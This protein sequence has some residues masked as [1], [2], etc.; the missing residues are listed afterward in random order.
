MK[1]DTKTIGSALAV[2]AALCLSLLLAAPRAHAQENAS[3]TRP[4]V[5]PLLE[6]RREKMQEHQNELE[7]K[8]E[9]RMQEIASTTAARRAELSHRLEEK[10][11]EIASST[12]ARLEKFRAKFEENKLRILNEHV[13]NI[14]KRLNT[15]VGRYT[16][17]ATRMQ[18]RIDRLNAGNVNTTN[19]AALLATA[20]T[21]LSAA[22]VK[23]DA[24]NPIVDTALASSSPRAAFEELVKP[25]VAAA[26]AALRDAHKALIDV[27]RALKAADPEAEASTSPSSNSSTG[28]DN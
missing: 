20:N 5:R 4:G 1:T 24:I 8:R 23:V 28:G 11:M 2:L 17:I 3:S 21:K 22:K 13:E 18:S 15:V 7:Q 26:E 27:L 19:A 6:Q 12:E 25:A 10:R 9:E 16:D 14:I